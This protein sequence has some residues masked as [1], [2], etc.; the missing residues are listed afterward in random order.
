[1]LYEGMVDEGLAILRAI[2]ERYDGTR[3]NPWN[4]IECGDHYARGLASWGC[5]LAATGFAYDGPAG[6]LEFAPRLSAD[7]FRAFFTGAAGWGHLVQRRDEHEQRNRIELRWGSLAISTISVYTEGRSSGKSVTVMKTD[8][9]LEA[10]VSSVED[11]L[12]IRLL[13][14]VELKA[15]EELEVRIV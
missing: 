10:E 4:E 14:P 7:D 2:H 9:T 13:E 5:L 1:M 12:A 11:R 15:G 3:H 8:R 6:M